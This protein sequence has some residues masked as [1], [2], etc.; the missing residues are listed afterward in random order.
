MKKLIVSL[1]A[2]LLLAGC[3]G[4]DGEAGAAGTT[5]SR[6]HTSASAE[7][8]RSI[9]YE[10]GELAEDFILTPAEAKPGETVELRTQVLFDADIHVYLDGQELEKS[11]YDS[12]YW[13]WSFPMPDRDVTVSAKPYTKNEI[14]GIGEDGMDFVQGVRYIR[15][16]GY[17]DGEEYPKTFWLSSVEELEAYYEANKDKYW[18]D[19]EGFAAARK[20]YD[21]SFFENC[22][23]LVVLLEEGSG[24]VSHELTG[25]S[26]SPPQNREKQYSLRPEITR[27]VP[28]IGT[29]DMAEW[30]IL[31]EIPKDHGMSVSELA[32][33]VFMNVSG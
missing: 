6:T 30:H 17:I 25:I 29:C 20:D 32:E 13:G 16:D 11:H 9:Y 14:W 18:L 24:S 22:D 3:A 4:R 7:A 33:P 21:A 19:S 15:T 2:L 26:V 8:A 5:D 10:L 23:L 12:D 27:F 1:L 28:E 31:I